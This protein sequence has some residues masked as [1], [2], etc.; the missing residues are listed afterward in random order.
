VNISS[1]SRTLGEE[2]EIGTDGIL[3]TGN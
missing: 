1:G 2:L 3:G